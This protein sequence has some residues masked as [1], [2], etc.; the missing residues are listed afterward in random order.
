MYYVVQCGQM[1]V[2]EYHVVQCAQNTNE[3]HMAPVD[4]CLPMS[5]VWSNVDI[6]MLLPLKDNN[7][8][9]YSF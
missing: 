8:A 9:L 4:R 6:C 1:Y 3:C 5:S 2:N 7:D